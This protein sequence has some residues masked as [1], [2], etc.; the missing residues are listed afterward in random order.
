M[1]FRNGSAH[2]SSRH[3]RK[4]SGTRGHACERF[5][6]VR[7]PTRVRR[8]VVR[9][10]RGR[11]SRGHLLEV[12]LEFDGPLRA[13]GELDSERGLVPHVRTVRGPGAVRVPVSAGKVS[14]PRS[15]AADLLRAVQAVHM[16]GGSG[17]CGRMAWRVESLQRVHGGLCP[18]AAVDHGGGHAVAGGAQDAQEHLCGAVFGGGRFAAGLLLC[19]DYV[20]NGWY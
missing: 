14:E 16:S 6:G 19:A 10:H 15:G 18:N 9:E 11:S 7:R 4:H 3:A 8:L 17:L 1:A 13:A 20:S 12:H 2:S 5:A